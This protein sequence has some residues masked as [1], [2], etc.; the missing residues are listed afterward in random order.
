MLKRSGIGIVAADYTKIGRTAFAS[1]ARLSTEDIVITN[2]NAP[3]DDIEN[4][5][6]ITENI[7]LV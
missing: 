6:E 1:I 3:K 5:V 2:N 7:I 4:L